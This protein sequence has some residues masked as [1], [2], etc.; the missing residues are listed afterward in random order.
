MSTTM[1]ALSHTNVKI[2]NVNVNQNEKNEHQLIIIIIIIVIIII[3]T[4]SKF[5]AQDNDFQAFWLVP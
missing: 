3:T 5:L 1:P 4:I 2:W